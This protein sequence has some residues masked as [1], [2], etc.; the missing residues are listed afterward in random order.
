MKQLA[1]NDNLIS[2]V[3][4]VEYVEKQYTLHALALHDIYI[5]R[6]WTMSTL[7]QISLA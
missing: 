2:I 3:L 6:K 1:G 5:D 7:L 4:L